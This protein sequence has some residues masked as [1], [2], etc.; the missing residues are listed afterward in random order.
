MPVL[1]DAS[2]F[3]W[4]IDWIVVQGVATALTALIVLVSLA[5]A[6]WQ[7][8]HARE[9]R[10]DQ[11]R[12]HVVVDIERGASHG[13]VDLT[14]RNLGATA[15][16]NVRISSKPSIVTTKDDI[17]YALSES[18]LMTNGVPTLAPGREIRALFDSMPERVEA[19]MPMRYELCV[20]YRDR[21][22]VQY[23]ETA[24]INLKVL[25]GLL[26][27]DRKG[28]H[29]AAS[30]LQDIA[31]SLKSWTEGFRGVRVFAQDYERYAWRNGLLIKH[32]NLLV[33]LIHAGIKRLS[34]YDLHPRAQLDRL[35]RRTRNRNS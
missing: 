25:L 27:V 14:V 35:R 8:Q 10:N 26:S 33:R 4:G 31:K 15:A 6:W 1:M 20:T 21:L 24:I 9:L 34:G 23:A 28:A 5:F 7:L 12:P 22:K 2:G 18:E 32:P 29:E 16:Y 11:A 13:I 30:A 19:D 3:L 17:G